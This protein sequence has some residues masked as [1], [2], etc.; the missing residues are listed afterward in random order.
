MVLAKLAAQSRRQLTE[1]AGML[2][3]CRRAVASDAGNLVEL[4]KSA[5]RGDASRSGWTSEADFVE[6][7]RIDT[8]QVL[9]VIDSD[10]SCFLTLERA[11]E[12]VGC[13]HIQDRGEGTT[14][15]GTFSV[16][17][18]LQGKGFGDRLLG[19]AEREASVAYAATELEIAVLGQ[20]ERLI[21][22]YERRAFRRTG[23]TRPFPSDG[24][25]ARP[26]RSDLYFVVL[27]KNLKIM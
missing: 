25:F 3:V 8:D 24:K 7:D 14:Y 9:S 21:E 23:D 18:T 5:Y 12:I 16:R 4:I 2:I 11:G 19:E 22:W 10:D 6:G 1:V 15:F 27:K 20:Q 13:C 17:P 26:L